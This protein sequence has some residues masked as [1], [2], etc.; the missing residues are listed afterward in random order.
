MLS[1]ASVDN[2]QPLYMFEL[3]FV[4]LNPRSLRFSLV[5]EDEASVAHF[6]LR[7]DAQLGFKTEQVDGDPLM[8]S[9]GRRTRRLDEYF[10]EYPPLARFVD[11]S[12]LDGNLLIQPRNP[13]ELVLNPSQF[14]PWDWTGVDLTKERCVGDHRKFFYSEWRAPAGP[15]AKRFR[16]TTCWHPRSAAP[17]SC[18]SSPHSSSAP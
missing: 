8:I 13:R 12:E 11:L 15:R 18:P 14:E 4:S 3:T 7:L 17:T 10:C 2:P 1:A 5:T 9:L 16:R 6:E